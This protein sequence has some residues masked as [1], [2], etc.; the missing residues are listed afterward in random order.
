MGIVSA[1]GSRS[2]ELRLGIIEIGLRIVPEYK[3]VIQQLRR[4]IS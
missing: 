2:S 4:F 1:F 3:S